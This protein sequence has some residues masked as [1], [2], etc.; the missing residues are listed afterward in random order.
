MSDTFVI[1]IVRDALVMVLIL[2]MPALVV[3]LVVGLFISILQATTQVQ[4]QSLTFVPKIVAVFIALAF[5]A[6]WLLRTMTSFTTNLYGQL[7][8]LI[9]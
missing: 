5:L 4:E 9:R 1:H 2:S 3:S 7:P 6:P 8:N